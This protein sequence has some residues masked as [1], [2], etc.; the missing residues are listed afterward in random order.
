MYVRVRGQNRR[1]AD[2][3]SG[4]VWAHC[5]TEFV[6]NSDIPQVHVKVSVA[7]EQD[8]HAQQSVLALSE[9]SDIR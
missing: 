8:V 2:A 9:N 5:I 6:P 3:L 7:A 4:F 1:S